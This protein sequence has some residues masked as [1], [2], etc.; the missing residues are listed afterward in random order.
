VLIERLGWTLANRSA[1]EPGVLYT[2]DRNDQ[3][4]D[5]DVLCWVPQDGS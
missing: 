1:F 5:V 4:Y 3:I 2:P